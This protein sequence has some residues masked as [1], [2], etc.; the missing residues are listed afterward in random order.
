MR[1][2]AAQTAFSDL[3]HVRRS[4]S[5]SFDDHRVGEPGAVEGLLRRSTGLLGISRVADVTGLDRIGIPVVMVV[6]PGS[7]SLVVSQGKGIDLDQARVSGLMES[8]EVFHAE[9]VALPIVLARYADLLSSLP[10]VDPSLLPKVSGSRFSAG[11][12][13]PWAEAYDVLRDE[14]SLVPLELVHTDFTLPLPP[15][16]GCFQMSSNGLG[17]GATAGEALIHGISEVIERDAYALAQAS[18]RALSHAIDLASISHPVVSA[19]ID[20]IRTAS[21]TLYIE[22]ITSD[23]AV[24]VFLATIVGQHEESLVTG[25]PAG[26]VGCH[27]NRIIACQRAILEAAQSRVTRIA[28]SRDDLVA[29]IFTPVRTQVAEDR[30][31]RPFTEGP[32]FGSDSVE[33]NLE[34]LLSRLEAVGVRQVLAVDLTRKDVG[35]PIIRTIIPGLEGP[36]GDLCELG[37][38]ARAVRAASSD[39]RQAST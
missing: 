16:S 26:G 38:R 20:K 11:L 28:G 10:V 15:G 25:K 29:E 5:R 39:R 4:S 6:R 17:G 24:P 3:R 37:R 1:T 2:A 31:L 36:P 7:R 9:R 23:I 8:A 35:I 22:E 33:D 19:L 32:D 18:S 27:P 21:C 13:I 34:F 30:P 14:T 12:R